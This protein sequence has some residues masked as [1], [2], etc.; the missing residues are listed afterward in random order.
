MDNLKRKKIEKIIEEFKIAS[1][2]EINNNKHF[3]TTKQYLY[4]LNNG[5]TLT[6]EQVF[7]NNQNGDAVIIMPVLENKEILTVIEPRVFT[8]SGIAI[9]FP[10]GYINK[11]EGPI[12]AALRELREETGYVP[13]DIRHL[14]SFYQDEGCSKAYNHAYLATNCEKKFPQDL[15]QDEFIKY[16]LASYEELN[17]L[18][19]HH[20]INGLNSAYAILKGQKLLRERNE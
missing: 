8:A 2:E 10:A 3:I 12:N 4:T 7:K 15:D 13:K 6:R 1:C 20:Y 19:D 18:L 11:N 17:W 5:L 14:D 16:V 9:G